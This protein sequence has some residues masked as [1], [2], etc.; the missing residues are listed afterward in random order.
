MRQICIVHSEVIRRMGEMKYFQISLPGVTKKVIGAESSILLTTPL[1]ALPDSGS[2]SS[3]GS[4]GSTGGSTNACP[5]PGSA[6]MTQ[7]SN[8]VAGSVRTQV[9]QIGSA[10]NPTF[11]YGVAVYSVTVSVTAV[12]GD[13]PASIATKLA[14]AVNN[15]TLAEWNQYGSDTSG[16]KPT[17]TANADQLT[18]T[19]DSVH[20][21]AAWGTGSCTGSAP[22][23]PVTPVYDP[24]FTISVSD[25]AGIVSLQSPDVTDIFYQGEVYRQDRNIRWADFTTINALEIDQWIIGQ[26]RI[27]IDVE[28]STQSRIIE[29][30]YKDLL[31][32]LYNQDIS[33]KLNLFIWMEKENYDK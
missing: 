21:F 3:G 17:A 7:L 1:P 25:K 4:G 29:A 24:L 13:T 22:T 14:A 31:G 8:T 23:P 18:L 27:A 32:V 26:K 10:V 30:Y 11:Q 16:Y 2:G 5:N 20:Q 12:D 6:S 19:T 9:F 33:Y 15:T 28:I